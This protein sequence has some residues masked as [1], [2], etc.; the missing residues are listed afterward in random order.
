LSGFYPELIPSFVRCDNNS[1]AGFCAV[2][3]GLFG[4]FL[5]GV[6]T[7]KHL[8]ASPPDNTTNMPKIGVFMEN[9]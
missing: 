5:C 6:N 3:A 9:V 1:T 2:L 4:L 8:K 7:F